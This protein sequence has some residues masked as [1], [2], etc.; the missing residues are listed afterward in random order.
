MVWAQAS[1]L[2]FVI[3][4]LWTDCLDANGV[5]CVCDT[6]TILQSEARYR[7]WNRLRRWR[8]RWHGPELHPG[9]SDQER[10][11]SLDFPHPGLHDHRHR[12]TSRMADQ[13]TGGDRAGQ[14]DRMVSI[15]SQKHPISP[16]NSLQGPFPRPPLHNSLS[17][18]RN[19]HIPA[20]CPGLLPPTLHCL[21][22][23]PI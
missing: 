15:P 14:E 7:Q 13:R 22:R 1:A 12:A 6:G 8:P 16:V 11:Y 23:P 3:T 20:L 19:R 21:P 5:G 10:R 2:W 4:S 17:H 9:C 18:R